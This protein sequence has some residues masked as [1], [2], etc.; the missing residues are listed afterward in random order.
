M[1]GIGLGLP[2][3]KGGSFID[4][5]AQILFDRVIA[6]GG[7]VPAGLAGMD[8]YI[9]AAKAARGISTLAQGYLSLAHPHYTGIRLA[10][11]TGATAGNRAARTVYNA[12]GAT[13]D[14]IQTTAANQPLGLVNSGTNYVWLPGVSGN[15]FSTP[16]SV[17]NQLIGD[18]SIEA[19]VRSNSTSSFQ[20]MIG[21]YTGTGANGNFIF[22][23]S[24]A[25]ELQLI[26]SQG[27]SDFT[28]TSTTTLPYSVNTVF[29][30][31]VSRNSTTGVV[32]F[33][34][35]TTGTSW[36][37]LGSDVSGI[38]GNLNNPN[39]S[40]EV[41][42]TVTGTSNNFQG[43]IYYVNLYKDSTFTTPTQ[44]F[45]PASYNRATSQTSWTSTTG[46]VWTLNTP[47]TNNALKAAIVDTTII[48]GNGTSYGLQAASLNMNQAAIT[49][50]TTFRR[51]NDVLGE[52]VTSELGS[53]VFISPGFAY[54]INAFSGFESVDFYANV[55]RYNNNYSQSSLNLALRTVVRN[56]N[57]AVESGPL[58]LNNVNVPAFG[59][60]ASN[61]NTANMNAT[62][63]NLL[64]R[65]NAASLWANAVLVSDC[66]T[67]GEDNT[68]QQTSMYNFFKTYING[69]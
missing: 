67:I 13:G 50:Y 30:A 23:T 45:N 38:T 63:Y 3:I 18:F 68:T 6:D 39:I 51:F 54:R 42:S 43:E 34:I 15:Y 19:R 55:G 33:F 26:V 53:N 12:I 29:F 22:R 64:A 59:S 11:G 36:T 14:F 41:G 24:N 60:S 66:V 65:N 20:A 61:N 56:I 37:Q 52:Q 2:F 17:N 10:T 27:A 31:R 16:N 28:Y 21:K 1:I 7:I 40:V 57:N 69:I 32:R 49:S 4:P 58:L 48:M 44:I 5:E 8:A 46:E 47:N 62:G 35:S 9:K 25:N